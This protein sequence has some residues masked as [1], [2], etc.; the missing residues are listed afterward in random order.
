MLFNQHSIHLTQSFWLQTV[1]R[2]AETDCDAV[3]WLLMSSNGQ[4]PETIVI[5]PGH[6][7]P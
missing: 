2:S 3:E 1:L 6:A 5:F 7:E 4:E